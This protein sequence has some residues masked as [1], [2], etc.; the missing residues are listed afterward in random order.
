MYIHLI[1]TYIYTYMHI[2]LQKSAADKKASEAHLDDDRLC[3]IP[4]DSVKAIQ[5]CIKDTEAK[6][7]LHRIFQ[8]VDQ[9]PSN[10]ASALCKLVMTDRFH[11]RAYPKRPARY[12]YI[13]TSVV[14]AYSVIL[15]CTQ[16][17]ERWDLHPR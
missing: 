15:L 14:C 13:S 12:E 7:S 10:F 11:D 9:D 6:E 3:G 2:P 8:R 16:A 4:W 17:H 5:T 1:Y